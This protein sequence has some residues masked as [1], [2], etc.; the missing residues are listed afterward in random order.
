[1]NMIVENSTWK[2][3]CT[4]DFI[5]IKSSSY[6]KVWFRYEK[7]DRVE[8]MG[9]ELFYANYDFCGFDSRLDYIV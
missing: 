9:L 3:R 7:N 1:M 5:K 8:W 2:E 6:S 4:G